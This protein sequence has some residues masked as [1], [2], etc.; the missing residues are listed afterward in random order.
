MSVAHI[1][2]Q[3]FLLIFTSAWPTYPH[4]IGPYVIIQSLFFI[5]AVSHGWLEEIKFTVESRYNVLPVGRKMYVVT[6]VRCIRTENFPLREI[7]T[8]EKV[9]Y[10]DGHVVNGYVVTRLDCI[11]LNECGRLEFLTLLFVIIVH[12]RFETKMKAEITST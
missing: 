7:G 3:D 1:P 9:R 11:W 10:N 2:L 6:I 8:L 12:K 4:F 5:T